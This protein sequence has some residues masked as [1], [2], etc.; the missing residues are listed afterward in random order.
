[1]RRWML[2]LALLGALVGCKDNQD[3]DGADALWDRIHTEGYRT[4]ARAPGYATRKASFT[5]HARAVDIYVNPTIAQALEAQAPLR[6]WP[7]GSMVVKDGFSKDGDLAIVAVMEKRSDGWYW[8]EFDGE[9]EPLFSGR[10][11]VCI[12]CHARSAHDF[13]WGFGLP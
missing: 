6:A 7:E 4:W 2:P 10:P 11:R 1:M 9:G 13:T 3:P 12:D 8:V 5:A